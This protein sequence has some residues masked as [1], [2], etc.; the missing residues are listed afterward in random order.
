MLDKLHEFFFGDQLRKYL[1]LMGAFF[2]G[3]A[4]A[5]PAL[6]RVEPSQYMLLALSF[7]L[8]LTW[9]LTLLYDRYRDTR[10]GL[11]ENAMRQTVSAR[12][13]ELLQ[14]IVQNVESEL[15]LMEYGER[16]RVVTYETAYN[17]IIKL[18]ER[19]VLSQSFLKDF[20]NMNE[21]Y[22]RWVGCREVSHLSSIDKDAYYTIKNAE[23]L[24]LRLQ[25]ARLAN[26][27]Y[28][29]G[30]SMR[31]EQTMLKYM[32]TLRQAGRSDEAVGAFIGRMV[33]DLSLL[34]V[35]WNERMSELKEE[36]PRL[37]RK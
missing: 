5:L 33:R 20:T 19:G 21:C 22:H 6:A 15:F 3:Q 26:E 29:S 11:R 27:K 23:Q 16:G 1:V 14:Q 12:D 17:I 32:D 37:M 28:V 18:T 36:E 9:P 34:E 25:W 13:I 10:H 30:V 24:K 35:C 4:L 7:S 8:V 31:L 2:G